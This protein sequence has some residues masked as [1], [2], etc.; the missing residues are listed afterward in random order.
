MGKA[1]RLKEERER[2][3]AEWKTENDRVR[4]LGELFEAIPDGHQKEA[5][6]DAMVD[7]IIYLYN[8][9]RFEEGDAIIEFLP[10]DDARNLLDWY[11]DEDGP[12]TFSRNHPASPG[13]RRLRDDD[14]ACAN[15]RST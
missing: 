2:R 15:R 11:F 1:A 14:A 12:D 10:N 8:N 5:L 7:R 13:S 4:K 9:V 6:K 3:D